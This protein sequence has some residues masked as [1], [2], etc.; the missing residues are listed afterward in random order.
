[1]IDLPKYCKLTRD[2]AKDGEHAAWLLNPG[3]LREAVQKVYEAEYFLEDVTCLD[4]EEGYLVVHHYDHFENPGRISLR[5]LVPHDDPKLPS[6]ADIFHGAEWHERECM[7][8]YPVIFE[9]NPNPS[10]LLL[11]HG[12]TEYPLVKDKKASVDTILRFDAMEKSECVIWAPGLTAEER[13][14]TAGEA[15]A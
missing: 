1:M 15:E 7:D 9:G 13:E 6:V 3:Q 4:V 8:F 11:E 10:R 2:F 12:S 14:E 5:V